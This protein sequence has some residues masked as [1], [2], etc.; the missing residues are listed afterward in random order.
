M[1][2]DLAHCTTHNLV[3]DHRGRWRLKSGCVAGELV[4]RWHTVPDGR[5]GQWT[6]DQTAAFRARWS[7]VQ[8]PGMTST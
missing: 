1:I 4:S 6:P 7:T 8:S 3:Q 5:E 2:L